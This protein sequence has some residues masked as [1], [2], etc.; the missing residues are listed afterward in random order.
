MDESNTVYSNTLSQ[1]VQL[2]TDKFIELHGDR[3]QSDDKSVCGGLA[4]IEGRKVI[5]ISH[6]ISPDG[7]FTHSSQSGQW[8]ILRL[9]NLAKQLRRPVLLFVD[10]MYSAIT[11]NEQL[12]F[13]IIN[14]IT[15]NMRV[16]SHL[17]APIIGI[18]SEYPSTLNN[19]IFPVADS[20]VVIDVPN[21]DTPGI[22]QKL[23]SS[24]ISEYMRIIFVDDV[25]TITA[26][27]KILPLQFDELMSIP[28]HDLVAHRLA[29]IQQ[30]L[31]VSHI[32]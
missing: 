10:T 28:I 1:S 29:R 12:T 7:D 14:A 5:L 20:I 13:N 22:Y 27:R 2:L 15:Q 4:W 25:H 17:P 3:T 31:S 23:E 24:P 16:M 9:L 8:K 19:I 21:V 32:K 26:L 18:S 11:E 30:V 6:C